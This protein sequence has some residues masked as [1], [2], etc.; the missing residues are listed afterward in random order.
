M[1]NI[2][3]PSC[4][5]GLG[6]W[7]TASFASKGRLPLITT[8][9]RTAKKRWRKRTSLAVSV[10]LIGLGLHLLKETSEC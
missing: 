10:W 9:C 8:T 4:A 1:G 6:V 7:E 5:I 2:F 3:W